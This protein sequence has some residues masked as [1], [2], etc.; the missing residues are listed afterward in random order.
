MERNRPI[1]TNQHYILVD[2]EIIKLIE[3]LVDMDKELF[4]GSDENFYIDHD[5]IIW[6]FKVKRDIDDIINWR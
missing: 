6:A 3:K 5:T 2:E 1:V 4:W